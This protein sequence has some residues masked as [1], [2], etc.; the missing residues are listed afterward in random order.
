MLPIGTMKVK[1]IKSNNGKTSKTALIL[2]FLSAF[3]KL[4]FNG[5]PS[6]VKISGLIVSLILDTKIK[7]R[8]DQ[9]FDLAFKSYDG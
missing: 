2:F 4:S 3:F 7:K 8:R 6:V 9:H 1:N 5:T